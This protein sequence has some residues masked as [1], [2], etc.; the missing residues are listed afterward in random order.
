ME[1]NKQKTLQTAQSFD[2]VYDGNAKVL[3]MGTIPSA[4]GVK[5]GFF[6]MSKVNYFWQYLTQTLQ[7]DDFVALANAYR[8]AYN[9]PQANE[10][11]QNVKNALY[12]NHIALYDVINNCERT[13]SADNEIVA[14]QNNSAQS[15]F[16]II[17]DNP[18]IKM[19]FLNSYE[20]EKRFKQ[21]MGTDGIKQLQQMMKI[22]TLPYTRILSPSP[23]CRFTYSE[24]QILE[25]WKIIKTYLD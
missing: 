6:Y 25:N 21:I 20:V 5:Y 18:S 1:K 9:T 7:T 24:E 2:A 10:C 23:F 13:G 17:Q 15:I 14:S 12:K 8:N 3:M 22:D 19:I 16:K 4:G 11:K